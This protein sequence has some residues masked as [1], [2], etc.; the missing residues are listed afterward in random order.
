VKTLHSLGILPDLL[1][2]GTTI[3]QYAGFEKPDRR[4]FEVACET[5][6]VRLRTGEDGNMG[7][8]SGVLMVG[9]ELDA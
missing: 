5:A 1:T 2:A 7:D 6:G 4:I 9:D 3:S 8:E